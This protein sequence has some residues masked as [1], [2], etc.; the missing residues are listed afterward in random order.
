[1]LCLA[2][3]DVVAVAHDLGNVSDFAHLELSDWNDEEAL[4][5]SKPDVV[6]WNLQAIEESLLSLA[7]I[8]VR[9]DRLEEAVLLVDTGLSADQFNEADNA[10]EQ[11]IHN[12]IV[13]V[14]QRSKDLE[15]VR[16]WSI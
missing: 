15:L 2:C 3:S 4:D 7:V 5:H 11:I 1:M 10:F 13:Q 6:V 16:F 12:I 9:R 14:T 8:Q